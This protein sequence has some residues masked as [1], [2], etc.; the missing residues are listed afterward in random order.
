MKPIGFALL[1][2]ATLTLTNAAAAQ[3]RQA[4]PPAECTVP[5]LLQAWARPAASMPTFQDTIGS[6]QAGS[7]G[8]L[9]RVRLEACSSASCKPDHFYGLFPIRVLVAGR[10]RI[11]VDAPV[12]IDV[13]TRSGLAEGLMCEHL[14]CDPV[15]KVMQF[16]LKP[17]VQWV[18]LSGKRGADISFVV[19]TVRD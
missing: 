1:T 17:G 2:L 10:Y 15:R 9:F 6:E 7:V 16:E 11:A 4:S 13:V 3:M 19:L 12:W 14:G 18:A 8:Q 5:D